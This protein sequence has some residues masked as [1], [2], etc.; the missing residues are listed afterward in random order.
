MSHPTSVKEKALALRTAGYSYSYISE[1]TGLSK[2]T[3]SG[4]LGRVPYIPNTKTIN[5]IG[6]ALA[7]SI[8]K[9][10][11][12]R[13]R[14]YALAQQEAEQ[15][16]EKVSHRDIF[17]FG[18][19]L[20]LGEGSKTHDLVRVVNS[21]PRVIRLAIK[22][23]KAVGLSEKNLNIRLH[24]YPDSNIEES[25]LFWISKT[26]LSREQFMKPQIDWRKNKKAYKLGKLP[27]GTAH[28]GVRSLGEKRHGV[29]LSRK[30]AAWI[31]EV[32]KRSEAGV[33]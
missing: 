5:D 11:Q 8:Q 21:D 12:K 6:K 27:Y 30:I 13:L 1:Q 17:M 19:G 31:D 16:I 4:W 22:W 14:S 10:T 20:Y 3:L 25:T 28:V 2:S 7:A 18:L 24:L 15:E 33:V 9:N 23:F 26:G 29:F 32:D